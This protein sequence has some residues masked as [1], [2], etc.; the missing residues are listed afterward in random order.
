MT[1]AK[2]TAITAPVVL[3]CGYYGEDNL[4]DNAL[5]EVLLQQ[6]PTHCRLLITAWNRD[7][8]RRL[9]PTAT[10]VNRRSLIA[11]LSST[12]RVNIVIFGGGSLLQDSTSLR[13]LIYYVLL[14]L[15]SRLQRRKVVLWG[16][17][18]GPLHHR[19]SRWMVRVVLPLCSAVSWRD[20]RSFEQARRWA[21]SLPSRMAPDPVWQLPRRCWKGGT[22]IVLSWR[23]TP[24]LSPADWRLLLQVLSRLASELDAPVRWLA[25]HQHQDAS[26]LADLQNRDL[27][28]S[29]LFKRSTTVIPKTVDA[30]FQTV[31]AAR[32]VIPMRLHALILARLCCCPMAALSYDPKVEAA[33]EMSDVPWSSLRQLPSQDHLIRQWRA[34]VDQ[35]A[36]P[37]R[38]EQIRQ[39]AAAHADIIDEVI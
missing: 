37:E 7:A 36:D 8:I 12:T 19:F 29:E 31:Q 34:V 27:M 26:L 24:L 11:V 6:L 23:P 20:Q 39:R 15:C 38:I 30:V 16:Q 28:P 9:A 33:A 13:S 17:G 22:S 21:P 5:L 1:V 32:I 14:I 10:V 25:F 35:P 4:G 2:T 3:L 18:L